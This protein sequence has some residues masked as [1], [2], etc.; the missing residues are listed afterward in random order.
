M[1]RKIVF[2]DED[3]AKF[4]IF[5][6]FSDGGGGWLAGNDNGYLTFDSRKAAEKALRDIMLRQA[7]V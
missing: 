5:V 6:S 7:T 4:G 1:A 3:A 2:T